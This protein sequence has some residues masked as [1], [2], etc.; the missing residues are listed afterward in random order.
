MR[1]RFFAPGILFLVFALALPALIL[2]QQSRSTRRASNPDRSSSA[3]S[4]GKA[5]PSAPVIKSDLAEALSVIQS[6][7]IDGRKLDYNAVFKSSISGML[8]VLDPHSTYFDPVEYASF[9]TEQRSEYFGIGATIEDLREG[10][11]VNTFI[12]ATFPDSPAANAGLRFGDR[13]LAVD[14]N[15]MKGKTYPEVRKFLIGTRGT[16][17]KVTVEHP[18]NRQAET[19][20][21]VRDAVSLPSIAQAYML[22]PGVG[23]VAMT[24]GFNLTTADEFEQALKILHGKGMNMLVLDLRGNRGG[25]LIQAVRVANTF[26]QRGQTIVSQKGRFR[27]SSQSYA[28]VNENPDNVAVVVLV[29]GETA[30]AA[31]IVAGALQD[32]DRA[33]IV[34]ETT[35]GKGLVQ[36]P[37]QLDHD[38]ALLLTIAKYFTPSGRLIQRDYSNGGYNYYFGGLA[39]DKNNQ[40]KL[41]NGPESHTDMGRAVYGGGGIAPDETVKPGTISAAESHLR[42]ILFAFSLE[43]TTG[44]V[45]GFDSYKIQRAIEFD[46]DLVPEDY[47]ITDALFK[48]LKT[49]ASSKPIFKVT[50]DQ[51]DKT[52]TFAERRLRYNVLSAAYG[53]RVATQVFNDG[54][55]QVSRAV[56]AMP[57]ARE[58]ALAASR[59]RARG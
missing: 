27:D 18:G 25:L 39:A 16:T 28:A 17:V 15:S 49:F 52:R 8:S 22:R 7:H 32:H 3:N 46:H 58:L 37:F 14:G 50:P 55:P 42:D 53:Y 38:S 40:S 13:I 10:S 9:R 1:K 4:T 31:E 43:L 23:Y 56:D 54:D 29:N 59:A 51:L 5:T 30:S 57:R 20:N 21:I 34:G 33:L 45:P 26:L 48:E 2:A 44:R 11:D 12:R 6:N 19:V 41:Q 24:G 35:F 36:Y 47:P